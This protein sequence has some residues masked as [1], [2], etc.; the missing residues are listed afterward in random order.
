M[1]TPGLPGSVLTPAHNAL[2]WQILRPFGTLRQVGDS[3]D[4][5]RRF[6]DASGDV[7][8]GM[9]GKRQ[10]RALAGR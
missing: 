2:L 1:I 4:C 6:G 7:G 3:E 5:E 9:V 10:G 8:K